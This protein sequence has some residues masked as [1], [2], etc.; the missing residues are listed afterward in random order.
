MGTIRGYCDDGSVGKVPPPAAATESDAGSY[1]GN[2]TCMLSANGK[3]CR[4]SFE[5]FEG[6]PNSARCNHEQNST[7]LR[8]GSTAARCSFDTILLL[9]AWEQTWRISCT[10]LAAVLSVGKQ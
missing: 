4:V 5:A 7:D 10:G 3:A 8:T 1:S 9:D 6:Q 2:R